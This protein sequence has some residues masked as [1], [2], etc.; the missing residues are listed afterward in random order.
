MIMKFEKTGDLIVMPG[1]GWKPVAT[2]TVEEVATAVVERA[3]I[4]IY[5]SASGRSVS[6]ELEVL[7]STILKDALS[8][9]Y[10]TVNSFNSRSFLLYRNDN[11]CKPLSL[12]KM[13]Q[14]LTLG[15]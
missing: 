14:F 9:V 11:V 6:C 3:S 7:W 2:E 12:C 13:E 5:S 8:R 1:R 10:G 4:S 15:A